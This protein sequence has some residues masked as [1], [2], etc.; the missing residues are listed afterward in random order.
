MFIAH[1]YIYLGVCLFLPAHRCISLYWVKCYVVWA[2]QVPGTHLPVMVYLLYG[3]SNHLLLIEPATSWYSLLLLHTRCTVYF[4][5]ILT[6][7]FCVQWE[8]HVC[9]QG[10]LDTENLWQHYAA[11]HYPSSVLIREITCG[12]LHCE[13]MFIALYCCV[14]QCRL[15]MGISRVLWSSNFNWYASSVKD[16]FYSRKDFLEP[17]RQEFPH[18]SFADEVCF[19]LVPSHVLD[20]KFS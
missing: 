2:T 3:T 10:S 6:T 7:F 14:S 11:A 20:A 18:C 9:V 8:Q 5:C 1:H 16:L 19:R 4:V 12:R 13:G 17:H 15:V